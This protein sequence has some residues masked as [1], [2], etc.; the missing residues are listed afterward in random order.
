MWLVAP[1][2]LAA[3]AS[4]SSDSSRLEKLKELRTRLGL[5]RH[6]WIGMPFHGGRTVV[7][8]GDGSRMVQ[9]LTQEDFAL[10]GTSMNHF[11]LG[12]SLISRREGWS[13]RDGDSTLFSIVQKDLGRVLVYVDSGAIPQ[14]YLLLRRG[15]EPGQIHVSNFRRPLI[16]HRQH[17]EEVP[18]GV[19]PGPLQDKVL[20]VWLDLLPWM[21]ETKAGLAAMAFNDS[22]HQ[23]DF[24]VLK[25]RWRRTQGL[26]SATNDEYARIYFSWRYLE[27]KSGLDDEEQDDKDAL[28][29]EMDDMLRGVTRAVSDLVSD[30][31]FIDAFSMNTLRPFPRHVHGKTGSTR[32]PTS[33]RWS[34]EVSIPGTPFAMLGAPDF[35]LELRMLYPTMTWM[36]EHRSLD[37]KNPDHSKVELDRPLITWLWLDN[38]GK[39]LD[40]EPYEEG[41]FA[42][43]EDY[44]PLR[45][46][47]DQQQVTLTEDANIVSEDTPRHWSVEI[48]DLLAPSGP[49]GGFPLRE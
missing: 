47:L 30:A 40:E 3:L 31:R 12:G 36:R 1:L 38:T 33:I 19:I 7:T 37:S 21:N 24:E 39:K 15:P 23:E 26:A 48:S 17:G 9:L 25:S 18:F 20:A 16:G 35:I 5:G 22:H 11:E 6:S 49:S 32:L 41:P 27:E 28:D 46:Q 8:F 34:W 42:L 14:L 44:T 43:L 45:Q 4:D 29:G 2:L 13:E 10:A